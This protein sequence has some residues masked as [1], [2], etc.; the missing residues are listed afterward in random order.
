MDVKH[1]SSYW[2]QRYESGQTQWDAG[3]ITTP[4][5]AYF[6]QLEDKTCKILIPGC[7][8]AYEAAYLHEKGFENVYLADISEYPLKKFTEQYPGF[9]KEHILHADFFELKQGYD[10]IIEQTFFCA[11]SPDLR[12][13]YAKKCFELLKPAGHLVGVLFDAE[14]NKDHPPYG[15]HPDEYVEYFRPY[16]VFHTWERCYNSIA[17]RAGREWFINLVKPA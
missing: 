1:N 16:F 14:L 11:L 9:P 17:P 4:L 10:L 13:G 2:T 3:G 12:A 5:K 7:G 6:G 8:N 15:G